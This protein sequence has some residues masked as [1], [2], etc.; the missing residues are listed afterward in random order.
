[1]AVDAVKNP[2]NESGENNYIRSLGLIQPT[3]IFKTTDVR[4]AG[5]IKHLHF[6]D[7]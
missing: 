5:C 4:V 1:V 7:S 3:G 2:M 6:Q